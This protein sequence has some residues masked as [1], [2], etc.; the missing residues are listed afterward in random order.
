MRTYY[1]YKATNTV[2]GK[3]Y[4]GRT[5]NFRER[6]WQHLRCYEKED[7]VFHRAIQEYG[8]Q[9]FVWEVLETTT[10]KDNADAMEKFYINKFKTRV[11]D[12]YNMN[13]GGVGGHNSRPVVCLTLDGKYV[14][15]YASAGEAQRL[16]GFNNVNVLL[17]CKNELHSVKGYMFMFED[18]Y[19][20]LGARIFEPKYQCNMKRIVQC[21][22]DG[23]Y[24]KTFESVTSAA[25]ELNILRSRISSNLILEAKTAGGYIFVYEKDFPI[26]DISIYKQN[27]KGRKVAQ[28][29]PKTGEIIEV[30]DR[31]SEAGEK[32]GVN[33]KCIHKVV[34][35]EDKTA[36]G[37]KWVSQ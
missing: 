23:N 32:L 6:K 30:F 2:N 26:R 5:V 35:K 19:N 16:G 31:I 9:N 24:I 8:S 28:I 15:R 4:I 34:D 3:S 25:K 14:T 7:C 21:D 27:K 12:G 20:E 10:N 13:A 1:I 17:N 11:P 36:Y 29:D 18:D 37:F 33:Y 22:L